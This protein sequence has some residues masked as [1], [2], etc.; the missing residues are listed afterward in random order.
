MDLI[1][2]VSA[3]VVGVSA[4]ILGLVLGRVRSRKVAGTLEAKNRELE[5]QLSH[6]RQLPATQQTPPQKAKFTVGEVATVITAVAAL[7]AAA[8]SNHTNAQKNTIEQL[9]RDVEH[10]KTERD[11][12]KSD[13]S[14]LGGLVAFKPEEWAAVQA[15]VSEI[16]VPGS[17]ALLDGTH[18]AGDCSI[19]RASWTYKG[20]DPAMIECKRGAFLLKG[21]LRTGAVLLIRK[22]QP[23]QSH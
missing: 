7:V 15:K 16:P 10:L 18:L 13:A 1:S 9:N 4:F 12:L 2:M 21:T 6:L 11:S 22:A 23:A 5:G 3:A 8:G 14:F 20:T 17:D 19:R